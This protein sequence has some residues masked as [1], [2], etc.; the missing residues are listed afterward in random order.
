MVR[1]KQ[2][3]KVIS[4]HGTFKDCDRWNERVKTNISRSARVAWAVSRPIG[5][6][7]RLERGLILVGAIPRKATDRPEKESPYVFF[8]GKPQKRMRVSHDLVLI[9]HAHVAMRGISILASVYSDFLSPIGFLLRSCVDIL[10]T[11]TQSFSQ[12]QGSYKLC[13]AP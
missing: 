5:G 1:G 8:P 6:R 3:K 9:S 13:R 12:N 7:H 4:S 2:S 10:P 11:R